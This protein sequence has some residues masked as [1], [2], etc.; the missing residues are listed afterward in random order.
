MP[1]GGVVWLCGETVLTG[2]AAVYLRVSTDKQTTENQ[3]PAVRQ[4]VEARGGAGAWEAATVYRETMSA[5]KDRPAFDAMIEGARLGQFRTLFV[6]SIDRFGRSM[7]GNLRDLG[8]LVERYNVAVIS[9]R[10]SWLE[11]TA[12]PMLRKLL[13]GIF[14]WVAEHERER[15]QARTRAGLARAVAAGKTLGR[16]RIII[17][18]AALARACE[19]RQKFGARGRGAWRR[20]ARELERLGLGTWTHGTLAAACRKRVPTLDRGRPGFPRSSRW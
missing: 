12:D 5:A 9:V 20:V 3:E 16:P 8:A 15:L 4:L 18:E 6:W 13:L 1:P 17:P 11:Q 2:R 19:L 10:E 7:F 14:S